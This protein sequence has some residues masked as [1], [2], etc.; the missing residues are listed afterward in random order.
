MRQNSS[1]KEIVLTG[2][3]GDDEEERSAAKSKETN[4][5]ENWKLWLTWHCT[6]RHLPTPKRRRLRFDEK[7]I[8]IRK[9]ILYKD[10][11]ITIN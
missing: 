1:E 7:R 4:D 8:I 3:D 5:S 11:L 6:Q 2:D 9:L 10:L